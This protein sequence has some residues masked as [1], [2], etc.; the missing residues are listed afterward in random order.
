MYIN[1][2][3][4]IFPNYMFIPPLTFVLVVTFSGFFYQVGYN[5]YK[6]I[7]VARILAF[8]SVIISILF[9]SI[10]GDYGIIIGNFLFFLI[11]FLYNIFFF[12][13]SQKNK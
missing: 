5:D 11:L 2:E 6:N 4:L 7:L 8:I 9:N 13:K 1:L 3:N 10:G 12:K